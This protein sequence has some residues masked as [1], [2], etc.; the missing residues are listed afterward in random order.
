MGYLWCHLFG[1]QN[2]CLFIRK[3]L[4][5][6]DFSGFFRLFIDYCGFSVI[7][8]FE[9]FFKLAEIEFFDA[10]DFMFVQIQCAQHEAEKYV[11]EP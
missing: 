5:I 3:R 2:V 7:D 10:W 9:L 8:L 1:W 11:K 6:K 4:I